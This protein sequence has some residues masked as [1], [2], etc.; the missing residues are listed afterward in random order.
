[1]IRAI[2]TSLPGMILDEKIDD[3]AV[4][5]L[6]LVRPR[7]NAAKRSA[8]LPLPAGRDNQYLAARQAHR[9]LEGD[10][11]REIQEIAGCLGDAEYPFE[12]AP[13]NADAAT[14]LDRNPADR[15]QPRG[16][17]REGRDQ[18]LA[19]GIRHLREEAGV[20]A[21]LGTRRLV[22]EHVG[23][24][25]HQSEHALIAD[26]RQCLVLGASP[27]T[28]VSSIFQSPVWKMFPNG[29][30]MSSPF[31]S[32]IECDSATKL[33]RNG[34][35]SMLPPRSTILSFTAPVSPSSSSL[36]AIRP[37]VNGVA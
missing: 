10:R 12:R 31:P 15:L 16:V 5:K 37:A 24:I 25:A 32:G 3:I 34:P 36:P 9:F 4:G 7:S 17:R 27:S 28:G 13:G 18:D 26:P 20:D 11:R 21:L 22:L 23:G 1:M 14:G 19:A 2:A 35:S 8:G 6:E 29:V 33:T 30:S